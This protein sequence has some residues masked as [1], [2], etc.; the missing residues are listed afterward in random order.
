MRADITPSGTKGLEAVLRD[1]GSALLAF[2]FDGVLAPIVEDPDQAKPYPT[3]L[4]A[5]GRISRHVLPMAIITG[6][7][8]SFIRAKGWFT[9][10]PVPGLRV[11]GQYG[12]ERW[13]VGSGP[14]DA[15]GDDAGITAVKEELSR[16]DLP[17][18]AL[19]EDKG[20]AVAVH[21][22]RTADPHGAITRLRTP[23]VELAARHSLIVEPGRFVIELRQ[24]GTD[25]GRTLSGI[26]SELAAASVVYA[27][28][29]LGDLSA[30]AAVDTLSIPGLKICSGSAEAPEVA[31]R[32]DLT[33]P[34]PEGMATFLHDLAEILDRR[35]P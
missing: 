34:G 16:L 9:E 1:P 32:A 4:A 15:A 26:V 17:A 30:F 20:G 23:L 25:K 10:H 5:L 6:R 14:Q 27:G 28:D 21:T 29:D 7:P 8:V 3:M 12:R 33:V 18:G 22:R 35:C 31:A 11:F 19:I 24:A 2:D 13:D